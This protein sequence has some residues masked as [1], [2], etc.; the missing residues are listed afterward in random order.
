MCA[1][2]GGERRGWART[3]HEAWSEDGEWDLRT[4]ERAPEE[5]RVEEQ[6]CCL[7]L[8][9]IL[10]LG[11]AVPTLGPRNISPTLHG[12]SCTNR[13]GSV[14]SCMLSPL[15]HSWT[16]LS[17]VLTCTQCCALV[18]TGWHQA[19]LLPSPAAPTTAPSPPPCT[20]HHGGQPAVLCQENL[21]GE[22][23]RA[24]ALILAAL[25]SP[26]CYMSLPKHE[27]PSLYR[28]GIKTQRQSREKMAPNLCGTIRHAG[29]FCRQII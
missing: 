6:P 10:V 20:P 11:A 8:L 5:P 1:C 7:S 22:T 21:L 17:F 16:L 13:S 28:I 2:W 14:S 27:G 4:G 24:P 23:P 26:H 9:T 19:Q 15:Q 25:S 18:G 29:I 3:G 12:S